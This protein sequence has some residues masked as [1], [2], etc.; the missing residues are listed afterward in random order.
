ML[1]CVVFCYEFEEL[2]Y[3]LFFV[4]NFKSMDMD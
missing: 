3:E 2:E 4:M 1:T